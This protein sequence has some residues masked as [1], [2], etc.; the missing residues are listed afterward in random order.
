MSFVTQ[1][2][3]HL[4]ALIGNDTWRDVKELDALS[5]LDVSKSGMRYPTLFVFLVNE[6]PGSDVRGSGPYLQSVRATLGV[7]IVNQRINGRYTPMEGI[8]KELRKALFGY[9]PDSEYE[10][11]WLGNG[12]L[13][14]VGR[15][16]SS[17]IDNFITEYTEDQNGS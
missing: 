3:D 16:T 8:R 4:R 17:W 6:S 9:S 12:R 11:F 13:I 15:G 14:N 2:A 10:P 7:V 1:C 5:E